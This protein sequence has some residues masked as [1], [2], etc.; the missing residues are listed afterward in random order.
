MNINVFF[1]QVCNDDDDL[2]RPPFFGFVS[3]LK[4]SKIGFTS[5]TSSIEFKSS[6]G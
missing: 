6:L 5:M 3:Q 4:T 2:C 1:Q